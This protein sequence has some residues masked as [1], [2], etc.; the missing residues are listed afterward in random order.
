MDNMWRDPSA[1]SDVPDPPGEL[2]PMAGQSGR[3]SALAPHEGPVKVI[4]W[5]QSCAAANAGR[6]ADV[7]GGLPRNPESVAG[8]AGD[9]VDA[10][11][12]FSLALIHFRLRRDDPHFSGLLDQAIDD[13]AL[14]GK[15]TP[16]LRHFKKLNTLFRCRSFRGR[17]EAAVRVFE[18][19]VFEG[20]SHCGQWCWFAW[21]VS[22]GRVD[23]PRGRIL[24]PSWFCSG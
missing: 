13:I 1:V 3:T 14:L 24:Q 15:R 23:G 11:R 9:S 4:V 17:V 10:Q 6:T 12:P 21:P 22:R 19:A 2:R 20:L 7:R 16:R 18:I 5:P 8:G